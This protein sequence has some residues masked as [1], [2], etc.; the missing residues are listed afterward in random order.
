M[1]SLMMTVEYLMPSTIS[2]AMGRHPAL[3]NTAYMCTCL[4]QHGVPHRS[5]WPVYVRYHDVHRART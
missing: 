3:R 5:F 2:V 4:R 1:L